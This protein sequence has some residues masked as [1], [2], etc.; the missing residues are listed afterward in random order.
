MQC[1]ELNVTVKYNK[2]KWCGF[3]LRKEYHFIAAVIN[4]LYLTTAHAVVDMP[5]KSAKFPYDSCVCVAQKRDSPQLLRDKT[6]TIFY[7]R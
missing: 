7:Y 2:T 4:A 3:Q 1:D 6:E 5:I